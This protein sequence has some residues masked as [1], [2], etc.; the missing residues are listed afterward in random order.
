MYISWYVA[1]LCWGPGK[2]EK[3]LGR[4]GGRRRR[5]EERRFVSGYM[6]RTEVYRAVGTRLSYTGS[7]AYIWGYTIRLSC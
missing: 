1:E 2:E 7:S 4:R 3:R 6:H 5:K